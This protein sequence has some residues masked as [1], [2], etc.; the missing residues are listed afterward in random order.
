M[1]ILVSFLYDPLDRP[2]LNVALPFYYKILSNATGEW[3][4]DTNQISA[5][6]KGYQNAWEQ[7]GWSYLGGTNSLR[8][9]FSL[10][11]LGKW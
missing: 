6:M 2:P 4:Q 7:V 8:P 1:K 5:E 3:P 9:L 10:T 11:L